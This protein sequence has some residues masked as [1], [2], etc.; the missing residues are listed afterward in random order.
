MFA[1]LAL[2]LSLT[3]GV[4]ALEDVHLTIERGRIH[5][6]VGECSKRIF[7]PNTENHID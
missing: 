7:K 6:L 4:R 5:C 2:A 1:P 3:A